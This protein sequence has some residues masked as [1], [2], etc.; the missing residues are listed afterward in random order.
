MGDSRKKYIYC[1]L[2][3]RC[4]GILPGLLYEGKI[5][6]SIFTSTF[7]VLKMVYFAYRKSSEGI[8]LLNLQ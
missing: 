3:F 1:I 6:L 7:F 8:F 2:Y 4:W 5:N